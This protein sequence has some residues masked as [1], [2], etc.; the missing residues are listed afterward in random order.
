MDQAIKIVGITKFQRNVKKTID[1][2]KRDDSAVIL[3]RDSEPEVV[4]TSYA[5]YQNLKAVEDRLA[6]EELKRLLDTVSSRNRHISEEEVVK[7]LEQ[8]EKELAKNEIKNRR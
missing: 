3:T 8:V 7:D 1:E 6:R 4:M 2:L 5:S